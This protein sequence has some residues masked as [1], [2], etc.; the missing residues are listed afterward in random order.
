[1][2][3]DIGIDMDASLDMDTEID[4][5]APS[6]W[7]ELVVDERSV[8]LFHYLALKLRVRTKAQRMSAIY[9]V[10]AAL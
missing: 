3:M 7:N 4:S 6:R 8:S 2:D 9:S 10:P 1:M 5:V